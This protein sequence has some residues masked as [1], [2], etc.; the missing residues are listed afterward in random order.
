MSNLDIQHSSGREQSLTLSHVSSDHAMTLLEVVLV[1]VLLAGM[2]TYAVPMLLPATDQA[3]FMSQVQ[4]EIKSAYDTAVLTGVPHRLVFD[5][6]KRSIHLERITAYS[7]LERFILPSF[8]ADGLTLDQ[9]KR[10]KEEN[11]EKWLQF[12][13]VEVVDYERD[14]VIPPVSPLNRA[15]AQLVGHRWDQ[16]SGYGHAPLRWSSEVYVSRYY[17]EHM[18]GERVRTVVDQ[19]GASELA[20]LHFLPKGYV[21]R[22]YIVFREL[23][24]SRID[25]NRPPYVITTLP[26]EGVSLLTSTEEGLSPDDGSS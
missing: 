15:K 5:F 19:K 1:T 6:S 22:A 24:G 18:S 13:K 21:E 16:V 26:Y 25:D 3:P 7:P 8:A 10:E 20:Y 9:A 11:Y 14:R 2:L 23:V 17:I 4:S 12:G